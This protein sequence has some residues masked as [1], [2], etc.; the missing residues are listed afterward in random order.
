M[1]SGHYEPNVL[2][3]QPLTLTPQGPPD[4]LLM[5][6]RAVSS[7]THCTQEILRSSSGH[8]MG[9]KAPT[10]LLQ[11][12]LTLSSW[13]DTQLPQHSW[14]F[15][16]HSSHRQ[17]FPACSTL[18]LTS[19]QPLL[20]FWG[21]PGGKQWGSQMGASQKAQQP[22]PVQPSENTEETATG[23]SLQPRGDQGFPGKRQG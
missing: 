18:P 10:A 7:M 8:Q 3:P 11:L 15:P 9:S 4:P 13:L 5:T 1:L 16:A 12:S 21:V 19:L 20:A 23:G 2:C 6:L 22:H 14:P 17:R